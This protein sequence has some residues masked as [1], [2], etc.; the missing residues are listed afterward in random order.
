MG[1]LKRGVATV[2]CRTL[3]ADHQLGG[4]AAA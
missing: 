3:V 1:R 4:L 2:V